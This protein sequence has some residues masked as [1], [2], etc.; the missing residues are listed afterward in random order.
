[1]NNTKEIVVKTLSRLGLSE[2]EA[3][4]YLALLELELAT[5]AE[6]AK[7]SGLNRSSTYVVIESL[8]KKGFAGTSKDLK[9]HKFF[10]ISPDSLAES[11]RANARESSATLESVE[12]VV[13]EL[14]ALHKGAKSKPVVKVYDGK[15]GFVNAL[16]STLESKEKVMR[17]HAYAA[18]LINMVTLEGLVMYGHRRI[19][20]KLKAYS[21]MPDTKESMEL[22]NTAPK[23]FKAALIP[24]SNYHLISHF[25]VWDD[26]TAY[27]FCSDSNI[28]TIVIESREIAHNMKNLFDM[29]FEKASQTGKTIGD[30]N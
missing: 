28:V 26:K 6:I 25:A 2:K 5:A 7:H 15:E 30:L 22:V 9:I 1:M 16:F 13:P 10:A 29:A 14:K 20:T 18:E 12:R 24:K 8:K 3:M 17:Y 19:Q 27:A 4:A 11:A 23:Y 21:I